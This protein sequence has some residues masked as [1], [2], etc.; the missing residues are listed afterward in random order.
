MKDGLQV[1]KGGVEACGE[2][3]VTA[4]VGGDSKD[5]VRSKAGTRSSQTLGVLPEEPDVS[6]WA[7]HKGSPTTC[8]PPKQEAWGETWS[9]SGCSCGE[10]T[11]PGNQ[12]R[13][14]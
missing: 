5:K 13:A 3:L 10:L 4:S 12:K 9:W 7:P 11:I 14:L 2:A 8:I 6:G 1:G